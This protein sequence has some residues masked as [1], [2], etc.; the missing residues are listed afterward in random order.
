MKLSVEQFC[1]QWA[2]KGNARYLPNKM[3]FNT[4]DFVTMAGEY[5]LS[6]FRTG[7][8]EGGFYGSGRKWPE[9]KSKWGRKFTHPVMND[10]GT[11]AHTIVGEAAPMSQTNYTQHPR[12]GLKAIY[13]RGARYTIRTRAWN[14]AQPGKRGASGGYAAVHNTDPALGLF[15]VRKGSAKRPEWRQFIGHSQKIDDVVNKL[16]VPV[17]FRGFPFP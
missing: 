8:L 10:T 2:P 4:H 15:T 17:I 13:R 16:F 14:T 1:E 3:E 6:R 12:N 5:T 7:F 9:R 11:L